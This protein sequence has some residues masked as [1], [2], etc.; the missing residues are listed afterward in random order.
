M[1]QIFIFDDLHIHR[2]RFLE[3][4]LEPFFRVLKMLKKFLKTYFFIKFSKVNA[5]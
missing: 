5:G 1:L 2:N 3:C 4:I